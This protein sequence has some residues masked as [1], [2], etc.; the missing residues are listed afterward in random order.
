VPCVD[1]LLEISI[2]FF[3]LSGAPGKFTKDVT[4][5]YDLSRTPVLHGVIAEAIVHWSSTKRVLATLKQ[6]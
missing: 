1:K 2:V 6:R 5:I 3:F 4:R